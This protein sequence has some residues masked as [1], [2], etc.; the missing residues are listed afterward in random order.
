MSILLIASIAFPFL[1]AESRSSR[2]IFQL[3][4]SRR[5]PPAS[6][7]PTTCNNWVVA[8]AN[9]MRRTVAAMIPTRTAFVRCS[10]GNPAAAK[11]MTMALSPAKTKSIMMT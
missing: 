9:V 8:A 4:Q 6:T 2:N 10:S 7:S 11:P 1:S 3:T 5:M